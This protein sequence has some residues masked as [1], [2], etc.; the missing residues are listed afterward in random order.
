MIFSRWADGPQQS[1]EGVWY[2]QAIAFSQGSPA[3]GGREHNVWLGDRYAEVD[4]HTVCPVTSV[5]RVDAGSRPARTPQELIGQLGSGSASRANQRLLD[6]LARRHGGPID[7]EAL[8]AW[9]RQQNLE[10]ISQL[11]S[12][13][14]AGQRALLEETNGQDDLE[15]LVRLSERLRGLVTN[16]DLLTRN[17]DSHYQGVNARH[18][19][20]SPRVEAAETEQRREIAEIDTELST[21]QTD[22]ETLQAHLAILDHRPE[23]RALRRNEGP[24]LRQ[25]IRRLRQRIRRNRDD[26]A[27]LEAE[28]ETIREQLAATLAEIQRLVSE[29]SAGRAEFNSVKR[30]IRALQV[31]M[32]RL[33]VRRR[34][35]GNRRMERLP[36]GMVHPGRRRGETN[37]TRTTGQLRNLRPTPPWAELTGS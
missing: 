13:F 23:I 14:T 9:I 33:Q 16:A 12:R 18:G 7:L 2:R 4:G 10:R 22:L 27:G 5:T 1:E 28:L 24:T 6:Q 35:V 29:Q 11:A 15:G 32:R 36:Y 8:R 20:A 17:E 25:A 31:R 37:H 26:S 21:S 30:E 34:S 19:E 3:R